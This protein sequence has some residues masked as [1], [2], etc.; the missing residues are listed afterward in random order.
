MI[1][2]PAPRSSP[3]RGAAAVALAFALA[4]VSVFPGLFDFTLTTRLAILPSLAC[5]LLAACTR[6]IPAG[7]LAA[8]AALALVPAVSVLWS[9]I[10]VQSIPQIVRWTSFGIM[11]AGFS[12]ITAAE[13]RRSAAVGAV[14]GALA[15]AVVELALPGDMPSG[16]PN[17]PGPV[18]AIGIVA[19]AAGMTGLPAVPAAACAAVIAAALVTSGFVT[20]W[21]AAGAGLFVTAAAR[22]TLLPGRMA[23]ALTLVALAVFTAFPGLTAR[24]HPS[25]E[26]RAEIWR[27]AVL[28]LAEAGPLG[29]GAG[30][31]RLLSNLR[32]DTRVAELAGPDRRVD[33]LHSD[34]LTPVVEQ[35]LP[36]FAML[37]V[38]ALLL[39]RAR[40]DG[41]GLAMLAC[42]CVFAAFD[43]PLATPMGALPIAC[44]LGVAL[45][46]TGRMVRLHPALVAASLAASAVWMG[47]LVAGYSLFETGRAAGLVGNHAEAAR[48][49]GRASRLLPFEERILLMRASA[50]R[51][52][53][54]ALAALEE[55]E[56]F[57]GLYPLYWQ[58]WVLEAEIAS[59]IGRADLADPAWLEALACAPEFVPDR[60][61]MAFNAS[62]TVPQDSAL[63]MITADA[64]LSYSLPAGSPDFLLE[65]ASR[66]GAVASSL[67]AFDSEVAGYLSFL[68]ASVL[69]EALEKGAD[70]SAVAM[71]ASR[72]PPVPPGA[73]CRQRW[74][75]L[76]PTLVTPDG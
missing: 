32:E 42:S 12:G 3:S 60:N 62:R 65:Y 33:E 56:R 25:L 16:N 44:A 58:G 29:T 35:G 76:I 53:G 67:A 68:A 49:L 34:L 11:T 27:A 10:P 39:S 7:G 2:S 61:L 1:E 70:R 43:L 19:L 47:M 52:S 18:L 28:D 6:G 46:R 9:A 50:L 8:G 15:C 48:I 40:P 17:R 5:V 71:I 13:G 54:A 36:G 37:A 4:S 26:L 31:A 72:L 21:L 63:L 38:I 41:A 24:I 51:S 57:N 23:P 55:A 14:A 64:F 45:G 66:A 22:R 59:E 69:E 73:E 30:Q 20:A 74:E 75:M